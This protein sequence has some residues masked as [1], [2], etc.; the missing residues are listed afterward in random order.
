M[1]RTEVGKRGLQR[2]VPEAA[3]GA[4]QRAPGQVAG[5]V[6]DGGRDPRGSVHV[7]TGLSV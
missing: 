5:R 2:P 4:L 6:A 7:G 1:T 3:W